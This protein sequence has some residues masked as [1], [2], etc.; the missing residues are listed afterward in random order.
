MLRL[1][2]GVLTPPVAQ[3]AAFLEELTAAVAA[4]AGR[5]LGQWSCSRLLAERAR[6]TR[7]P[8]REH[9]QP[10]GAAG[11]EDGDETKLPSVSSL[12]AMLIYCIVSTEAS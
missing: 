4:G 6:R 11:A 3:R 10:V 9:A 2:V 5:H 1:L 12:R 7:P 8:E